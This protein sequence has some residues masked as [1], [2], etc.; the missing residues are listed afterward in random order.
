MN[1]RTD[2]TFNIKGIP[3]T[4]NA[5][6]KLNGSPIDVT[7]GI[8][9]V[10]RITPAN[11]RR[12]TA[13]YPKL[14]ESATQYEYNILLTLEDLSITPA[15]LDKERDFF[16]KD[17]VSQDLTI[18][19]L[20][21]PTGVESSIEFISKS[22]CRGLAEAFY[23][24]IKHDIVMYF[25]NHSTGL[26]EDIQP[27]IFTLSNSSNSITIDVLDSEVLANVQI[28]LNGVTWQNE[29]TFNGLSAGNY[30]VYVKEREEVILTQNI[31]I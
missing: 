31:T 4:S 14:D 3:H 23:S 28:S 22:L 13:S 25:F 30:T 5:I 7:K 19:L 21:A 24:D 26:F 16:K 18:A 1:I 11:R 10:E 17:K 6:E 8:C 12:F 15:I 29:L 27:L 20:D 2:F 9:Y